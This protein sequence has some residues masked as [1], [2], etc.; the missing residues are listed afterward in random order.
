[1]EKK[2]WHSKFSKYYNLPKKVVVCIHINQASA[3][4]YEHSFDS[5]TLQRGPVC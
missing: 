1:M 4:L 2:T 3:G 5:Y